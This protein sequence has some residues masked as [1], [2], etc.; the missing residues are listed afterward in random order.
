M[1][2]LAF[3]PPPARMAGASSVQALKVTDILEALRLGWSDFKMH[4]RIGLAFGGFYAVAGLLLTALALWAGYG[5][6]VF[7]LLM[8]FLLIGPVAALGVYEISRRRETGEPMHLPSIALAF[9]RHGGGQI[10]LFG[11]TLVFVTVM[12]VKAATFIYAFYF[13]LEPLG[14]RDVVHR[15][16]TS[17]TGFQF[18]L[19]GNAVGAVLA[20]FVFSL[21]VFSLPMLLDR[22]VDLVSA[23]LFSLR[24]VSQNRQAMML[25]AMIIAGLTLASF[26]TGLVGLTV[27]LPVIG[28]ASWRLYRRVLPSPA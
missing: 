28:H 24:T 23:I 3:T 8:G 17:A 5:F 20:A 4:A 18:A 15:V 11:L 10:A 14:V 1:V 12:W 22:D 2:D 26:A 27:V 19:V 16:L 7:P 25:W 9:R 21:S 6:L 13:G